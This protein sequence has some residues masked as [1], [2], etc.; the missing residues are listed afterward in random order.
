MPAGFS[1]SLSDGLLIYGILAGA[2]VVLALAT[3]RDVT[4]ALEEL[5]ADVAPEMRAL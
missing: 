2:T 4:L 5:P 3:V 1:V